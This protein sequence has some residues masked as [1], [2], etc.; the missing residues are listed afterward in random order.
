MSRLIDVSSRINRIQRQIFLLEY[1][2][3]P[4]DALAIRPDWR[5]Y[6]PR[7]PGFLDH[8]DT[9]PHNI[10]PPGEFA[11][12]FAES[13][14]IVIPELRTVRTMEIFEQI[15]LVETRRYEET[16]N[17][18]GLRS[19]PESLLNHLYRQCLDGCGALTKVALD[20]FADSNRIIRH[21]SLSNTFVTFEPLGMTSHTPERILFRDLCWAND[22]Y[23][24]ALDTFS[25]TWTQLSSTYP[26]T[27]DLLVSHE[28][29]R[30]GAAAFA[31]FRHLT[32]AII[33]FVEADL[34]ALHFEFLHSAQY[35][36]DREVLRKELAEIGI[37]KNRR[38][39]L[40][41]LLQL[42]PTTLGRLTGPTY[43]PLDW[44]LKKIA[45]FLSRNPRNVPDITKAP[46]LTLRA[47]N[48]LF[49]NTFVHL[50]YEPEQI[51]N[52]P[53]AIRQMLKFSPQNIPSKMVVFVESLYDLPEQRQAMRSAVK[54][55]IEVVQEMY[56]LSFGV[57]HQY[58]WWLK[59][60]GPDGRFGSA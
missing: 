8:L 1:L 19:Y 23:L 14:A 28:L 15:L 50:S 9:Y 12:S 53:K 44:K 36:P 22:S 41:T 2:F 20:E 25:A 5:A 27:N 18:L 31:L 45:K 33:G 7:L 40:L 57:G 11:D 4:Q 60:P 43:M 49:R 59:G 29:A 56:K 17:R 46:F 58:L 6:H 47:V 13:E 39:E 32:I 35:K 48:T 38:D 30:L 37:S 21:P 16:F 52:I 55:A 26:A 54:S 34:N 10:V 24:D 42:D 3:T 51:P